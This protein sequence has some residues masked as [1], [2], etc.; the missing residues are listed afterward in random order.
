[1]MR[2]SDNRTSLCNIFSIFCWKTFS[3]CRKICIFATHISSNY[4]TST[5][6]RALHLFEEHAHLFYTLTYIYINHNDIYFNHII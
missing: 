2:G 6:F 4:L 1:M 3:D 5:F